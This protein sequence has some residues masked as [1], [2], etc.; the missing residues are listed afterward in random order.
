MTITT[1]TSTGTTTRAR[2]DRNWPAIAGLTYVGAWVLGLVAFGFGPAADASDA[3]I[4]RY[5][6]D[7][8]TVSAIQSLL[9]HG[10]AA[11]ALLGVM[12]AV[13]GKGR[14]NRW[15]WR[16]V[17]VA[18][19]VS[20]VQCVLDVYRSALANGSTIAD[21]THSINRIDGVK[22]IALAMMIA[23]S[24]RGFRS[25]AMIGTKMTVTGTVAV[26][27]LVVSG[28]AYAT[29]TTALLATTALSLVL[30]LVWVGYTGVVTGRDL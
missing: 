5:F 8:R 16:A 9:I 4:A 29:A 19:G 11:V 14:L 18:V 25:T 3:D 12:V 1:L 21:L 24:I 6:A 30:L 15:A 7:H 23:T 20:L 27:A 22:M 2:H 10:V 28:I 26:V 13:R 17:L